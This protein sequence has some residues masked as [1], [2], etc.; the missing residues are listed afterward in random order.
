ML[1]FLLLVVSIF[2]SLLGNALLGC[3]G[4]LKERGDDDSRAAMLMGA[5]CSIIGMFCAYAAGAIS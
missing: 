2:L 1:I 3:G 5:I 4:M